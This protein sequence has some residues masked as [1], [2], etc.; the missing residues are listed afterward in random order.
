MKVNS[1]DTQRDDRNSDHDFFF[2]PEPPKN[3]KVEKAGIPQETQ[4]VPPMVMAE[5][6]QEGIEDALSRQTIQVDILRFSA[7]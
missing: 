1:L 4:Q 2:Q 5:L 7:S 6:P 3:E